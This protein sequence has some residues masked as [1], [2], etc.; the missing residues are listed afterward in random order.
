MELGFQ[1]ESDVD[2]TVAVMS[3]DDRDAGLPELTFYSAIFDG[4]KS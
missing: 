2:V 3:L 1:V 4:A